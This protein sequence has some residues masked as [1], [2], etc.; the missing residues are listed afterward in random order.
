MADSTWRDQPYVRLSAGRNTG[1]AYPMGKSLN[2]AYDGN[3]NRTTM[4]DPNS[5]ITSYL[6]DPQDNVIG[7]ANPF[8]ELTTVTYDGLNRELTKTLGNS[9]ITSHFY[10]PVGNETL[11]LEVGPTG[12]AIAAY[13]ATYDPAHCNRLAVA[14]L[15][16]NR[17]QLFI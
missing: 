14:E 5:G 17:G 16:G 8:A 7:I 13:T 10:D 4:L 6:Y 9:V 15:D 11:K 2:Y 3:K 12:A 1:V